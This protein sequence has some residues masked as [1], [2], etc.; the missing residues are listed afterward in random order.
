MIDENNASVEIT[1]VRKSLNAVLDD[2][3]ISGV[4]GS[5]FVSELKEWDALIGKK[6]DEPFT[7]VILGE[8]KRG[9][10]TIINAILGKDLTP[11]NATPET[12]TINEITF[13]NFRTVQAFLENGRRVPLTI[14]DIKREKLEQ[15]MKMFPSKISYIQI[16]D[17]SPILSEIKIVDTPGLSDLESL[18]KEV[19]D[20]IVNADA[21]MYATSCLLPF[22]ETEQTFL[23]SHVKPQRFSVLYILVNMLDALETRSDAQ[24]ILRRFKS[25]AGRIVPNAVVYGISGADEYARR[26]GQERP[27]NKG[28]R[29]LYET[30]FLQFELSLKR[31][32]LMQ[33]DVIRSQRVLTMLSQMWEETKT[34][35]DLISEMAELDQQKLA[36]KVS[37]IESKG[38]QLEAALEAKKPQLHLSIIEM[39]QQAEKW[40]YEFFA[41]LRTNILDCRSKDANGVEKYSAEEIE[42]FFYPYLMEKVGEAYRT[43]IEHHRDMITELVEKISHDLS[44]SLGIEEDNDTS[45]AP[46]VERLMMSVNK[47]VTRRVMGVKLFGTS[48]TFPPAAMSSFSLIL[49]KKK[50]TDII[51][52]AL[53]NYDDI[54]TNIVKDIKDVYQDLETKALSRL[55][56]IYKYQIGMNKEALT[57]TKEMIGQLDDAQIRDAIA[58]AREMLK[59][60]ESI[61]RSCG[62]L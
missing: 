3:Q 2:P 42:K 43:C 9:K 24:R 50:Q 34:K 15:R 57:Q 56:G 27:E 38:Q 11:T 7:L 8:F 55:E 17:N 16:K 51:D 48:E 58:K 5:E 31:D 23:A 32:I 19:R 22:S 46:S 21:I 6:M 26:M 33:K 53:E 25:I 40:M 61:L 37:D 36:E 13:G 59:E 52:I 54:R 41:K 35:L 30:Q 20:Y 18:D 28:F 12:Y 39:Q 47:N 44:K 45:K 1:R 14:D 10:S 49:K 4:L 62:E 29:D 60:P